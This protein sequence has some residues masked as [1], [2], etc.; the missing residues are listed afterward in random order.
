M[1]ENVSVSAITKRSNSPR[2]THRHIR[3]F[4]SRSEMINHQADRWCT[5]I[6]VVLFKKYSTHWAIRTEASVAYGIYHWPSTGRIHA[7]GAI[8][9]CATV[10]VSLFEARD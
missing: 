7:I 1:V 6:N 9:G 8:V 4:N 5:W 2:Q 10:T 3:L